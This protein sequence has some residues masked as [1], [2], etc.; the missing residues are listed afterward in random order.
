MTKDALRILFFE[1]NDDYATMLLRQLAYH[2]SNRTSRLKLDHVSTLREGLARIRASD[3]EYDGIL[4][5]LNLP[6]SQGRET[7]EAMQRLIKQL[8]VVVL[9]AIKDERWA[10]E[11]IEHGAQ[12]YLYKANL[13]MDT[14]SRS[15]RYAVGRHQ[16]KVELEQRNLEMRR[17][18]RAAEAA[19]RAKSMFLANMSHELRT[20]LNGVLGYAQLLSQ[21]ELTPFQRRGMQVIEENGRH[22]M[23]LINDVLD[24]ARIEQGRVELSPSP[25]L[26]ADLLTTTTDLLRVRAQQNGLTYTVSLDPK[27][28]HVVKSDP[29][30]LRQILIN[31]L[32]NAIKFTREGGEVCF[33]ATA[34]EDDQVQLTIADTGIGIGAEQLEAIFKPFH[35]AHAQAIR[36]PHSTGLGLAITRELIDLLDGQMEVTS[37]LG[38][39][40][41]FTLTFTLPPTSAPNTRDTPERRVVGYKG[42]RRT[43]VVADDHRSSREMMVNILTRLD[44]LIVEASNGAETLEL[45]LDLKPAAILMDLVMPVM[46]GYETAQRLRERPD[47]RDVPIIIVS[48]RALAKDE[49]RR[50]EAGLKHFVSKP[51]HIGALLDTLG[52]VIGLEWITGCEPSEQE[53]SSNGDALVPPPMEALEELYE[54]ARQGRIFKVRRA[55]DQLRQTSA[56]LHHG[57]LEQLETHASTFE[58]DEIVSLIDAV[59]ASPDSEASRG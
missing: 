26:L 28:P 38:V 1:D 57:F 24:L 7:I 29:G 37:E 9:T 39:G 58:T 21:T 56:P 22:L 34:L 51:I 11:A 31:L 46:D 48:A 40:T 49:R 52:E 20:P 30:K 33:T 25:F 41:T 47:T 35:Q 53:P 55:L 2:R 6:D 5:D 43:L 12:D 44:F 42:P 15:L 36:T 16:L 45:A 23:A 54:A 14:L 27:L 3:V 10:L 32:G 18:A 4:M 50:R 8:P 13:D 59:R 17:L 19:N